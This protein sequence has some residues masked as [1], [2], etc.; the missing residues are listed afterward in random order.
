VAQGPIEGQNSKEA[1]GTVSV[2]KTG[3]GASECQYVVRIQNLVIPSDATLQLVATVSGSVSTQRPTLR[4]YSGTQNYTFSGMPLYAT[5][6]QVAFHPSS[7]AVGV[8]DY[9]IATLTQ[10]NATNH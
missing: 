9:A 7:S 4:F 10:V 8:N 3:C 1:N 2:Y 5:F 6:T